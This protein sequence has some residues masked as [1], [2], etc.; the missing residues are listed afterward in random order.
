MKHFGNPS[1]VSLILTFVQIIE[2]FCYKNDSYVPLDMLLSTFMRE[3]STI[4]WKLTHACKHKTSKLSYNMIFYFH[5]HMVP[6]EKNWVVFLLL[7][8]LTSMPLVRKYI[9]ET[10]HGFLN[11]W[12]LPVYSIM[13]QRMK[14]QINKHKTSF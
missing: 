1:V 11:N 13:K 6:S 10:G 2:L 12:C 4:G 5:M 8:W 9:W 3:I 14:V 7:Y